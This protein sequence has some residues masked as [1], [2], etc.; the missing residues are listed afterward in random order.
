MDR[1]TSATPDDV[2]RRARRLVEDGDPRIITVEQ[3]LAPELPASLSPDQRHY[4]A[5]VA[6]AV[7]DGDRDGQRSRGGPAARRRA[8]AAEHRQRSRAAE[9]IGLVVT[10][11]LFTLVLA[12]LGAGVV[13]LWRLVL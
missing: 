11:V 7:L 2:A 6:V 9:R 4:A 8:R 13:G 5:A 1:R 12:V 3:H 10:V